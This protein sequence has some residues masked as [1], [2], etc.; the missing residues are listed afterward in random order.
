MKKI[1]LLAA[2][3]AL[4]L[5][6]SVVLTACG[7][8]EDAI[9][10]AD[11]MNSEYAKEEK[12]GILDSQSRL[13]FAGNYKDADYG[14]VVT[15]EE[16]DSDTET[17]KNISTVRVYNVASGEAVASLSQKTTINGSTSTSQKHYVDII[18]EEYFAVLSV[19]TSI[20]SS[21]SSSSCSRAAILS[22]WSRES[23]ST[24]NSPRSTSLPEW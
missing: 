11:I 24:S 1:K 5:C 6:A 18:S 22:F 23:N 14:F 8:K 4:I 12:D 2:L 21:S 20:S 15:E 19:K 13:S 7:N 17:E 10:I 9:K 16:K 3:M